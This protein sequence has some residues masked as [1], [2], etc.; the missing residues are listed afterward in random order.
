MTGKCS[1][2]CDADGFMECNGEFIDKQDVE[3]AIAWV[4]AHLNIDI[5]YEGEAS[6]GCEGNTCEGE[7]SGSASATCGVSAPGRHPSL[8]LR[9][10]ISAL[11]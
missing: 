8:G 6:G 1:G 2:Y 10:L 9:E 3:E 7:A 5:D 11:F 4:E